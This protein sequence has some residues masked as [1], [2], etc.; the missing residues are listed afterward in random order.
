M[1]IFYS[2]CFDIRR[3]HKSILIQAYT[4]LIK[5]LDYFNN[6]YKFIIYTNFNIPLINDKIEIINYNITN[7]KSVY[8]NTD[9]NAWYNM[10]FHKLIIYKE[11]LEKYGKSPIWIDLDTIICRNIDH[12][13][14]YDNFFIKQGT[15]D[16]RQFAIVN[17]LHIESNKYIQGNIWKLDPT[18]YNELIELWDS[19]PVKPHY[20]TQGLFNFAYHFKGFNSKMKIVGEDIDCNTINGLEYVDPITLKHPEISLIKNKIIFNDSKIMHTILHKEMQFMTFTFYT[21]RRFI[22]LNQFAQFNDPAIVK[23]FTDCG[24]IKA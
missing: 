8:N 24:F 7:I 19:M 21:L 23:F 4:G 5:S 14:N 11:L 12:L 9:S 1:N 2:F 6:N 15:E 13:E 3:I 16:T 20:D 18:L 17:N 22:Q 10:S